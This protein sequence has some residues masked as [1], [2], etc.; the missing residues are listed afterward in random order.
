M[1]QLI[2]TLVLLFMGCNAVETKPVPKEPRRPFFPIFRAEGCPCGEGC[3]CNPC[4]CRPSTPEQA[5]PEPKPSP[6]D[7]VSTESKKPAT[8]PS[9]DP[10]KVQSDPPDGAVEGT[11]YPRRRGLFGRRGGGGGC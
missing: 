6:V 9:T 8:V 3:L 2:L 10:V 5:K 7:R 1:L 4:E 11:Y